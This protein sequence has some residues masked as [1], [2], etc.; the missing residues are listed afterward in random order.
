VTRLVLIRHAHH[1]YIG[2]AI[3]GDLPG[4]FLSQQGKSQAARLPDRLT[5][6]G[7]TAIYSSPLERAIETGGP[8]AAR[9]GLKIEIRDALSEIH[10]GGFAGR[11]MPDLDLDP[12]WHSFNLHR[13]SVRAPGGEMMLETQARI[14]AALERIHA[15]HPDGVVAVVSHGDVIRAAVLHYAGIPLDFYERIE[16]YPASYSVIDLY[17]HGPRIV[18]LNSV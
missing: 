14:V 8:L 10:F 11:T 16:I 1:D 17:P 2:K 4:I 13:S 12:A 18:T 15:D 9:L 5:E 3:A 7:I 6:F